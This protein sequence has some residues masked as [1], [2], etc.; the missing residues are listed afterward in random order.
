MSQIINYQQCPCC[1]STAIQLALNAK[2]FTVSHKFF[3][4]WHC[5]NCTLRFTQNVPSVDEILPY[6]QSDSY[7]SHSDTNEGLINRL[8]HFIRSYTL[9]TKLKLV[10]QATG[11][12][13]GKLLDIGAGTG[14]FSRTMKVANWDVTA[15]EPD[16]TARRIAIEKEW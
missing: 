13:V 10:Q 9:K 14:Y 8:Y 11:L 12:A 5:N 15:L 7:V 16:A 4:V 2:D 1:G 3:E 6:Y